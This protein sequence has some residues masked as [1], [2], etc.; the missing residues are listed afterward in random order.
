MRLIVLLFLV[1]QGVYAQDC[2]INPKNAIDY[3][4]SEVT[5]CGIVSQVST[6]NNIR[7]N[8]TYFN[9]GGRFPNHTFTV[10]IWGSDAKKFETSLKLYEGKNI[11]VTGVVEIYRGKAQINVKEPEQIE[12]IE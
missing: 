4:G 2:D 7:G 3:E 1:F 12:I 6:P 5:V 11:A 8:P 9:L 10:I